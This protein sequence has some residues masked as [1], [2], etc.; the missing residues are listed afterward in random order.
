[1]MSHRTRSSVS[2][3]GKD[4]KSVTEVVLSSAMFNGLLKFA[5]GGAVGGGGGVVGV[6]DGVYVA[7]GSTSCCSWAGMLVGVQVGV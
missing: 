6:Y 7:L 4:T 2:P 5:S 1:V 3:P